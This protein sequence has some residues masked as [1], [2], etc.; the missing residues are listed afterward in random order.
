MNEKLFIELHHPTSQLSA[1]VTAE[2]PDE[3]LHS[4]YLYLLEGTE[5][6]GDCFLANLAEPGET[7]VKPV[8]GDAPPAAVRSVL[9]DPE[10]MTLPS[11]Q[12]IEVCWDDS[13]RSVL[14]K[15][16]GEPVGLL[17]TGEKQGYSK[18]LSKDCPWGRQWSDEVFEEC[19]Q[20]IT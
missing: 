14:A 19:F 7:I 16:R 5:V 17:L 12:E 9:A 6:V 13:G 10:P 8:D 2:A 18:A 11:E 4:L 20:A 3:I 15:L 1:V